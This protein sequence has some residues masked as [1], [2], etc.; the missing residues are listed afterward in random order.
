MNDFSKLKYLFFISHY[1][2]LGFSQFPLGDRFIVI[3]IEKN[4]AY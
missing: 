4:G 2:F 3:F 1:N